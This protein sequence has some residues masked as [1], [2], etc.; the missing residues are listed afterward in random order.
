MSVEFLG[1]EEH[2]EAIVFVDLELAIV[3]DP[4][5][6][7]Q[8]AVDAPVNEHAEFHV[9]KFAAGLEVFGGRLIGI[10]GSRQV[11]KDQD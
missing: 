7:T 1:I 3:E 5:A 2:W 4:F 6:V 8:H 11:R 10:L 9:L